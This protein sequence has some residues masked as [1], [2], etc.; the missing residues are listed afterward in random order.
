MWALTIIAGWFLCICFLLPFFGYEAM[1]GRDS[2][3]L[4]YDEKS[5]PNT[6]FVFVT[7]RLNAEE[8]QS[9]FYTKGIMK[10]RRLHQTVVQKLGFWLWADIDQQCAS[11]QW[12]KRLEA[13]MRS[14]EDIN[15]FVTKLSHS[16]LP[17]DRPQWDLY[18]KEDALG[19]KSVIVF[20]AHRCMGDETAL[21]SIFTF[22]NDNVNSQTLPQFSGSRLTM[23]IWTALMIPVFSVIA[24]RRYYKLSKDPETKWLELK[25]NRRSGIKYL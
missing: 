2:M 13:D 20:R 18:I 8:F 12:I 9:R 4:E 10:I 7:E 16:V 11:N 19:D 1:S 25:N 24:M 3:Y 23:K 14:T 17:E 22:V 15:I 21:L 5:I 6:I